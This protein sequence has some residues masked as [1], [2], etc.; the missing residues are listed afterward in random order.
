MLPLAGVRVVDLADPSGV[1]CAE[2]LADLG[3]AIAPGGPLDDADAVIL[4]GT[5]GSLAGRGLA[6]SALRERH[7]HLIIA[8]ISPFGLHGPRAEWRS[9]DTV[10]QA[11]GGMV[12]VNGPADQPPLRGLGPQA[13]HS[14]ALH[15]ALGVGLALLARRRSGR[16]QIID[17]SLQESAVA[18]LEHVTGLY[19]EHGIIAA[20]QGSLHWTGGFRVAECRDGPVLLSHLGDWT[21]LIEWVKSD[22]AAQ[23]LADAAWDDPQRRRSECVHVFDVLA[24]W[25]ARY[26]VAELVEQ[27]QLRRLPFAPVWPLG[28]VVGHPQLRARGFFARDARGEPFASAFRGAVPGTPGER[29]GNIAPGPGGA[30]PAAAG[31]LHG[32]RVLDFTWVVAGPV[33]TRVLADHGADVIKV[34][35]LDAPDGPERRGAQFANLNRGKRSIAVDLRDPRGIA[36]VRAL[37]RRCDVVIDNFSPRV[38]ANWGLDH[39]ALRADAPQ[40]ITVGLSGFGATGPFADAISYGPTL[41]AQTGFAWHMRHAGGAPSGWGFSYS[42]MASGYGAALAVLAALWARAARGSGCAI[43]LSQLEILAATIG[44]LLNAVRAGCVVPDAFGNRSPEAAAAPDGVYRCRDDERGRERWCAIVVFDDSEWRRFAAAIGEPAWAEDARFSTLA[45][46]LQHAGPLDRLVE[47]WT[48]T[49]TAESVMQTLQD[50][51]VAAGLVAD[52]RDLAEDPQLAARGYWSVA[53]GEVAVDGV[54]PCLSDTPGSV[55]GPGPRLGEHTDEVL[56][57]LLGMEQS[58]VDRL[59]LDRVVG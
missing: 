48:R 42:D 8:V 53:G 52:A 2:L 40:L 24:A 45:A 38:L 28:R 51:G 7:P 23:D 11:L 5:P 55:A 20:R 47:A 50:A 54:V 29:R 3:A 37:A 1:L 44:P 25:A 46:R 19:L 12:W 21:A 58:A 30:T 27:A 26:S 43:D 32:I 35:R 22:G 13:C 10:A 17:V 41:Q 18:A 34:E 33:A 39:Q 57:G 59:R 9:C 31:V 15:A 14:A 6:P 16:G 36:L 49:R 4:T 56:R